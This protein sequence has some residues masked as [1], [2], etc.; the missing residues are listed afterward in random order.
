MSQ[1]GGLVS[2]R[3]LGGG[4]LV[5]LAWR[6]LGVEVTLLMEGR[7]FPWLTQEQYL[8][9]K[10]KLG[11]CQI[12][13]GRLIGCGYGV[14]LL[15]GEV[16]GEL[17]HFLKRPSVSMYTSVKTNITA[18]PASVFPT[19]ASAEKTCCMLMILDT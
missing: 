3:R 11:A 16:M 7:G 14:L 5:S 12:C 19:F 4:G 17:G 18:V 8:C 6:P 2:Y 1:P 9:L 15:G 13:R 10:E